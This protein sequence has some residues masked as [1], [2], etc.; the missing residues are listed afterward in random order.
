MGWWYQEGGGAW[1]SK[2]G[3]VGSR[4][5]WDKGSEVMGDGG[6]QGWGLGVVGV[7]GW[8]GGV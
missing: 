2:D 5:W 4:G 6:G 7:K 1:E 3:V 8:S